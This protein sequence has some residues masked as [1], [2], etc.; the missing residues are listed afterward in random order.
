MVVNLSIA[1][2]LLI[3]NAILTTCY[4][5]ST[6]CPFRRVSGEMPPCRTLYVVSFP[7]TL[8]VD[9]FGCTTPN[10]PFVKVFVHSRMARFLAPSCLC[11]GRAHSKFWL[12]ARALTPL[13]VV[14]WIPSCST[15]VF[16]R[17][18]RAKTRNVVF[19]FCVASLAPT[20]MTRMAYRDFCL[21]VLL[22]TR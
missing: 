12:W 3:T 2:F 6:S 8:L 20:R 9:E 4:V 5:T 22:R 17:T 16:L 15:W 7:L 11:S 18:C 1:I 13:T 14:L 19:R 10:P 21:L